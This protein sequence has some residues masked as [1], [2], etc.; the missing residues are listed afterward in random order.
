MEAKTTQEQGVTILSIVGR[1]DAVAA[2]DV[3]AYFM[4]A[5]AES[6]AAVLLD[7]EGVEYISSGGIRSVI[8]LMRACERYG[9]RLRICGMNPFVRQVFELSNL[10]QIFD[11]HPG[12]Q[13]ALIAFQHE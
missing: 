9:S 10:T 12:R 1:L 7:L 4:Q 6:P 2:P 3:Q 8:M 11:I 5:V 13:D